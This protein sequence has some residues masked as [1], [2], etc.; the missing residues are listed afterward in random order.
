MTLNA[1]SVGEKGYR[2]GEDGSLKDSS[3]FALIKRT[4]LKEADVA[5]CR[6]M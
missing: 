6:E 4:E 3:S 2:V 5:I 1:F